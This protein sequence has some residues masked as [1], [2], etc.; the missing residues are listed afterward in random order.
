MRAISPEYGEGK[1][2]GCHRSLGNMNFACY[3]SGGV[4]YTVRA[5]ANWLLYSSW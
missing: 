5:S 2:A 3:G 1:G 4:D